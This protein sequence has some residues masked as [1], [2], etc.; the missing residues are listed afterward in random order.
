VKAARAVALL[1]APLL[2]CGACSRS[3]PAP[4]QTAAP[5]P[6]G[7]EAQVNRALSHGGKGTMDER[8]RVALVLQQCSLS[9]GARPGID[10]NACTTQCVGTCASEADIP[11]VDACAK[12]VTDAAQPL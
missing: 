10:S 3:E 5:A 2:A 7:R 12:R 4:S 9:C 6:S 8:A 11:A 1:V